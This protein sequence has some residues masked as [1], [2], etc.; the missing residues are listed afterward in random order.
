LCDAT[1]RP[2]T[3]EEIETSVRLLKAVP[4][5]WKPDARASGNFALLLYAF[6]EGDGLPRPEPPTRF[7]HTL[8][9]LS[10]GYIAAPLQIRWGIMAVGILRESA[11]HGRALLGIWLQRAPGKPLI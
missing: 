7:H 11:M 8:T 2:E 5:Q 10:G 4:D 3:I 9:I 1:H 6:I